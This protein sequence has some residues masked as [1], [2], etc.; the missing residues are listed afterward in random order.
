MP[1][2]LIQSSITIHTHRCI[3]PSS[4]WCVTIFEGIYPQY[5]LQSF[6]H[7]SFDPQSETMDVLDEKANGV[8]PVEVE[9]VISVH[10]R[11]FCVCTST[12]VIYKFL[13]PF[14]DEAFAAKHLPDLGHDAKDMKV[15]TW[16]LRGWKKLEKKL[17]SEEFECGG[18]M[19]YVPCIFA[20]STDNGP[21]YLVVT[22]K[23]YTALSIRQFKCS[24]KRHCICISRLCRP[25]EGAR[26]L[27]CMCPVCTGNIK[28]QR[29]YYIHCQP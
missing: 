27:A 5:W 29:P 8:P 15:F 16:T 9:E 1:S 12:R 17:T 3:S 18:H 22:S 23:A 14:Q 28:S 13:L 19:W 25:K 20:L 4:T 24:S 10:D 11:E 7:C 6:N 26:G 2:A 21:D